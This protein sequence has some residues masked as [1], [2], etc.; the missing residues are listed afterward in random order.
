MIVVSISTATIF[1]RINYGAVISMRTIT[2]KFLVIEVLVVL[3]N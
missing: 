2:A 3:W 1:V